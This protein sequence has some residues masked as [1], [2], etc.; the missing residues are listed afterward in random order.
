MNYEGM[1]K[2]FVP[3]E[4]GRKER[5]FFGNTRRDLELLFGVPLPEFSSLSTVRLPEI[6]TNFAKQGVKATASDFRERWAQFSYLNDHLAIESQDIGDEPVLTERGVK[7][8]GV[9]QPLM[10][11]IKKRF[12]AKPSL[13][14]F[15]NHPVI[16]P[17]FVQRPEHPTV[18]LN[19]QP[20][21]SE[22][23]ANA[24]SL[25][26]PVFSKND[27]ETFEGNT[28]LIR[29]LLLASPAGYRWIIN[30]TFKIQLPTIIKRSSA[31]SYGD[32]LRQMTN[33]VAERMLST[34]ASR[35][36]SDEYNAVLDKL[37]KSYC[38]NSGFLL[39]ANRD[40]Q[41]PNLQK[42]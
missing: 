35:I 15:H 37:L 25:T 1:S 33:N 36:N 19:N 3:T 14:L 5:F 24:L 8:I 11:A 41:D 16:T 6:V 23:A 18:K 20:L 27:L 22:Q 31:D 26:S 12:S 7:A 21:T 30:P 4:T 42:L 34:R 17:D 2:A 32:A 10:D 28:R 40:I 39:F 29:S 13:I 9:K 38:D